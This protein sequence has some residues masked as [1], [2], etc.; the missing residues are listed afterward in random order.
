MRRD[1]NFMPAVFIWR[2]RK[3][4][5]AIATLSKQLVDMKLAIASIVFKDIGQ[6]GSHADRLKLKAAAVK[7]A[8]AI[9]IAAAVV[10]LHD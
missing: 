8:I 7:V 3:S 1:L 9:K 10:D 4:C 2:S 6:L 5:R